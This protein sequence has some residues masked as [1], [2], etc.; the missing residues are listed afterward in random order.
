MLSFIKSVY[1]ILFALALM[2]L[3]GCV[4][5]SRELGQPCTE[6]KFCQDDANPVCG[7]D[8]V[9][10]A[11]AA[12]ALCEGATL[13][14]SAK[15]C[16]EPVTC[17]V[18]L[19][20]VACE[21]GYKLDANG[22]ETCACKEAPADACGEDRCVP[23][24]CGTPRGQCIRESQLA[25]MGHGG[26]CPPAPFE[27]PN[28]QCHCPD[29]GCAARECEADAECGGGLCVLTPDE[30]RTGYCI[31]AS[32]EDL[33]A[34]YDQQRADQLA[35]TRDSECVAVST[36]PSCCG[37][38]YANQ[39]GAADLG[40]LNAFVAQTSCGRDWEAHCAMVDCA[41]PNGQPACVEGSCQFVAN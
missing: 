30:Q 12:L 13:D 19:C 35:C 14:P 20:R 21:F 27:M 5:L 37:F 28:P 23:I 40:E 9:T 39:S 11:C 41:Q 4:D 7:Q 22:C 8:G 36:L 2:L 17:E 1:L 10:Y 34:L 32:C 18:P 6:E 15:G 29:E 33:R 38:H 26:A 24:S 25:P 31:N 16:A 3:S